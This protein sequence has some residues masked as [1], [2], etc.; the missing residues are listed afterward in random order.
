MT[1]DYNQISQQYKQA[2]QQPWRWAVETYSLM[3]LVGDLR[4]TSVVDVACGEGYFT[5]KLRQAG[6]ASV[7]GID[8]SQAMIELAQAEEARE[9]LGIEYVVEDARAEQPRREL[10][11]A[12]AAWLL[13]YAHDR[14]E[15]AQMCRGLARLLRPGGRFVTYTTNPDVYFFPN[16][17]YRKYGF[18]M[19]LA[20]HAYEGAPIDWVIKV[21][22]SKFEIQNYYLPIEAYQE[23]FEAAGFRDFRVH[24]PTLAPAAES[25]LGREFWSDF[26][27]YPIAV[28]MD[29]VKA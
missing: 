1:T 19:R 3:K 11:L 6:A 7:L 29:C 17:D 18:E 22:D 10:D 21:G 2:K 13:V 26:L 28:L 16:A 9:P 12:V 23:A 14:A 25:K 24:Q 5:R 15:L 8:I 4:G 20:D 27:E